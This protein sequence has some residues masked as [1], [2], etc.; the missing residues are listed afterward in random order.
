MSALNVVIEQGPVKR[1]I[2]GDF[3]ICASRSTLERIARIL[4]EKLDGEFYYG[5][6]DIREPMPHHPATVNS[7]PL[8]WAGEEYEF[9]CRRKDIP[10]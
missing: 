2:E 4:Q 10:F 9:V 6:V 5:W 1:K 3:R 7:E 8:P